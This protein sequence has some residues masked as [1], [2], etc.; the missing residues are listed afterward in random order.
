MRRIAAAVSLALAC[1]PT[2]ATHGP[3]PSTGPD[4]SATA[5]AEPAGASTAP[6][7][8][9]EAPPRSEIDDPPE[10]VAPARRT[11]TP[12]PRAPASV[13][14]DRDAWPHWID[15]DGDCQDTRTEVLI[16][17]SE[18]PVRFADA[19]RCEVASGRWRCPYTDRTITDPRQLD[20]DHLVPLAHAHAAGASAWDVERRRDF[21]NEL[22]DPDHL[23]AVVAAANRSK[24]A[25]SVETWLPEEPGFR[26][27]YV[28]A[29]HRIMQRWGLAEGDAER[30]A[31]EDARRRCAAN[32]VPERPGKAKPAV[33]PAI[34]PTIH[35]PDDADPGACCRVCKAGKACGDG[36]IAADKTCHKPAGCACPRP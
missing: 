23:I 11:P 27:E 8:R 22:G 17:E 13:A 15:A 18:I 19:R 4:A 6:I 12:D 32:D 25:R 3:V 10:I 14:F 31:I 29:W 30:A 26:C 5:D 20:V 21:A 16:A 28:A 35:A 24:G 33:H 9:S 36:C 1:R 34:D 7:A 2:A